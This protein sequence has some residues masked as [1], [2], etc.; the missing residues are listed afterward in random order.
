MEFLIK[1]SSVAKAIKTFTKI[2]TINGRIYNRNRHSIRSS[3]KEMEIGANKNAASRPYQSNRT[4]RK[5]VL[6][7]NGKRRHERLV[8]S[9]ISF[10]KTENYAIAL[11]DNVD[12]NFPGGK[13]DK[14]VIA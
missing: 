7:G 9:L 6:K 12:D 3:V 14:V 8:L 1:E 13:G 2:S 10:E 11:D 5:T 4:E